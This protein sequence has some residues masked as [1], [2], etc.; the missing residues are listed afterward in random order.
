VKKV[1][2]QG[3]RLD[4]RV[5][6]GVNEEEGRG[7]GCMGGNEAHLLAG[8]MKGKGRSWSPAGAYHMAKVQELCTNQ[9]MDR[10]CY[11]PP[12]I[13]KQPLRSK[14]HTRRRR[15]DPGEWLQASVPVLHGPAENAPWV[16]WLH[17]KIHPPYLLN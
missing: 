15:A 16:K 9:E 10:W 17:R 5:R 1:A 14:G 11:R 4:W 12:L 8:R 2:R 6:L 3:W 13:G 7:L